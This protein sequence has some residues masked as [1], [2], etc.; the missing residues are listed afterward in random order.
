MK[1][2]KIL[3]LIIYLLFF[4]TITFAK[5]DDFKL[6][7][8]TTKYYKTIT[9]FN[10]LYNV[11]DQSNSVTYEIT[12]E[13]YEN[14]DLTVNVNSN[15][16][17]METTY[18]TM[19]TSILGNGQYYRYKNVLTWKN[20]PANRSYDIIGIGF[21]QTVKIHSN[22]THFT[23]KYCLTGGTCYTT[24][25]NYPQIFV[26]GAGTSFALPSGS[27]ESLQQVFYFDV[28]KNTSS[29]ITTQKAFGDY[30][31]ATKSISLANS[32]KYSVIQSGGIVLNSSVSGYYDSIAEAIATWTGTW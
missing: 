28:E 13:E 26:S 31:H 23:Q 10:N 32:K 5:E 24:T 1:Y 3:L 25:T 17:I 20:M 15:P 19:T 18:K 8:E 21:Y 30:S 9:Y 16:T 2:G 4:P 22:S 6:I 29:V 11:S 7:S 12:K 27:L 14:A